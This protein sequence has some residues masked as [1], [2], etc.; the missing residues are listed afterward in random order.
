M[1]YK[2][3][4]IFDLDA[5]V[6]N[7][8]H[9]TPNFPDGT[10]NLELYLENKTRE[11]TL[12]DTLL[13]LANFWKSLDTKTSY[14]VVCTARSW[15]DFDQEFLDIHGLSAH[16]ILHRAADGSENHVKCAKLKIKWLNRVLNLKQFAKLPAIMFDDTASVIS[17]MRK[18]GLTCLNSFKVNQKLAA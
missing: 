18:N 17:E 8:D 6:V 3:I 7:S 11:N 16:K 10:L 2:N 1:A 12:K 9:R 4:V 5:T 15:A 14:I 13:P